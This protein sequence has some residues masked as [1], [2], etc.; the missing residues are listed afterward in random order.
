MTVNQQSGDVG[1]A[2]TN[3]ARYSIATALRVPA[4]VPADHVWLAAPGASFVTLT[5]H[6]QLR[7]CIGSLQAWR[8]LRD[9]VVSNARAAALHDPRFAALKPTELAVTRIEVSVLSAPEPLDFSSR[10]DA[11]AKLRP[12]IDG[13][14]L[15]ASGSRATFLPQ[16][17]DELPT[18]D[19]FISHLLRK[20]GLSPSY[21]SDGIRLSRYTVTAFAEDA[22]QS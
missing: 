14:I 15:S 19:V 20:A 6:G 11:L 10:E 16:V 2:L 13:V 22:P 4:P 17:W 21:W 18:P 3:L 12:G 9:D 5:Q 7:G 1:L 8:S